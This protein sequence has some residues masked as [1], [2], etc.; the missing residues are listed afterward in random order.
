MRTTSLNFLKSALNEDTGIFQ[1]H[2][3]RHQASA[4]RAFLSAFPFP[5]R[6]IG[7]KE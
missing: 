4:K 2:R 5:F 7:L 3:R 6:A 1:F